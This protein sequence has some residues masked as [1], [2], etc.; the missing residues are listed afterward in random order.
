MTENKTLHDNM[1]KGNQ[2]I[3]INS[4]DDTKNN[5]V[6]RVLVQTPGELPY[7]DKGIKTV[8]YKEEGF[9]NAMETLKGIH[10]KEEPNEHER[11][12]GIAPPPFGKVVNTGHCPDYGGY[13]DIEIYNDGYKPVFKSMY[14]DLQNGIPVKNKFSTDVI[15]IDMKPAG[16]G[17]YELNKWAYDE[18]VMTRRPRDPKTGLCSV[19][20]NSKDFTEVNNM[21]DEIK[22]EYNG[23]AF[24]SYEDFANFLK[25]K[26]EELQDK[27]QK[28]KALYDNLKPED[29]KE[30]QELKTEEKALREQLIPV[31][32]EQGKEKLELVNSLIEKLPEDEQKAAKERF[33]K[34]DIADLKLV[35]SFGTGEPPEPAPGVTA[36]GAGGNQNTR[37]TKEEKENKEIMDKLENMGY[38]K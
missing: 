10:V 34:M 6:Y 8:D 20:V 18:L 4:E 37:M 19:L 17:K 27:Y 21:T 9:P 28:G 30:Y 1:L 16:D 31:W 12:L 15:P 25:G 7:P 36:R 35:N 5:P 2:L 24:A 13:A 29:F 22:L 23:R 3:L 33:E 14:N 38:F 11:K 26:Y 32:N